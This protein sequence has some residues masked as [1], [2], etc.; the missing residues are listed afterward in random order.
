M[1]T[2]IVSVPLTT[3]THQVLVHAARKLAR[4][5][6][7]QT[8]PDVVGLIQHELTGRSVKGLTDE[9][10]DAIGWSS[11]L[12]LRPRRKHFRPDGGSRHLGPR[13]R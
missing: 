3:E 4:I 5:L 7:P 6:R 1:P 8:G 13:N 10:L 11:P 9:Y 2:I 12:R